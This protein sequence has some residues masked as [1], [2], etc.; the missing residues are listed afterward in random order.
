LIDRHKINI[1]ICSNELLYGAHNPASYKFFELVGL[2]FQ[3]FCDRFFSR[4]CVGRAF[5][6]NNLSGHLQIQTLNF[7]H[8]LTK[9]VLD[10]KC[11]A[12]NCNS[13]DQKV[14][15][16]VVALDASGEPVTFHK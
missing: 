14:G 10:R 16:E 3:L 13:R 1:E 11:I 6:G 15:D 12:N 5:F 7:P 8:I 4:C 9:M 2:G